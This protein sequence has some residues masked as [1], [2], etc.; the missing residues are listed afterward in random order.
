MFNAQGV[1]ARSKDTARCVGYLTKYLTKQ[2]AGCHQAETYAQ[3]AH[4][5]GSPTRCVTSPAR[6][7]ALLL[8]VG[9][10]LIVDWCVSRELR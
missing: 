8:Y 3:H 5:P 10:L 9:Q 7:G 6:P 1:L 2:I 4:A